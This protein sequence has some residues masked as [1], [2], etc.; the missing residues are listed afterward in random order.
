MGVWRR[1]EPAGATAF[2]HKW[3]RLTRLVAGVSLN[4]SIINAVRYMN[5]FADDDEPSSLVAFQSSK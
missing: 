5:G 4:R 3:R 1:G 2:R